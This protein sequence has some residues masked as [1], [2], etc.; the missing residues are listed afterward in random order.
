MKQHA[1]QSRNERWKS[2][3]FIFKFAHRKLTLFTYFV[4]FYGTALY[5]LFVRFCCACHSY[6]L[7]YLFYFEI[8][9]LV[10]PSLHPHY[11]SNQ[12]N[13]FHL[14]LTL[15]KPPV[16]HSS[17][18]RLSSQLLFGLITWFLEL[19]LTLGLSLWCGSCS[20]SGPWI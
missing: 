20:V 10:I 16:S 2:A 12:C 8:S 19:C 11:S 5:T 6:N 15:Y 14:C 17:F 7:H 9:C 1:L 18:A 4:L 3:L 13:W